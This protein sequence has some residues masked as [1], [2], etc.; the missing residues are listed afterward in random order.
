MAP[1][2]REPRR[3]SRAMSSGNVRTGSA[4][5]V[6]PNGVVVRE[7]SR[8]WNSSLRRPEICAA[9]CAAFWPSS[10]ACLICAS[11]SA[12]A[13]SSLRR[14]AAT[15]GA[16]G[17]VPFAGVGPSTASC[18]CRAVICGARSAASWRAWSCTPSAVVRRS[19]SGASDLL[20][21]S[22]ALTVSSWLP[23]WSS[24]CAGV[25]AGAAVDGWSLL[26]ANDAVLPR[27]SSRSR[28]QR[29]RLGIRP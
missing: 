6:R 19:A 10:C 18:A 21:F 5:N 16:S 26:W 22:A 25:A 11:R 15:S 12:C 24:V 1:A 28:R 13:L 8:A 9:S 7:A 20:S 29:N 3:L 14:C 2:K 27:I 4:Q 17:G 23:S